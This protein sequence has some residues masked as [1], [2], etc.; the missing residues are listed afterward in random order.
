MSIVHVGTL[1]C[2]SHVSNFGIK[3]YSNQ[4]IDIEKKHTEKSVNFDFHNCC[5]HNFAEIDNTHNFYVIS[6]KLPYL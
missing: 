3:T 4:K 1:D 2:N 6:K 5:N